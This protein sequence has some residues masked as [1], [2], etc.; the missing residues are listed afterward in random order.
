MPSRR[1]AC[2]FS[3]GCLYHVLDNSVSDLEVI[4]THASEENVKT[5]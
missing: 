1:N 2:L 4:I 3:D 5:K